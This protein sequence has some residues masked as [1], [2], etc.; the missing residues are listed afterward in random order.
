MPS[1]ENTPPNTGGEGEPIKNDFLPKFLYIFRNTPVHIPVSFF[2]RLDGVVSSFICGGKTPRIAKRKLQLPLSS[3]GLA[4]PCFRKYYWAAV[5]VTV[6]WWF[7]QTRFNPMVNLEAAIMGSYS[8]LTNLVYRGT[9]ASPQALPMRTTVLVW[10]KV[11]AAV[12]TPDTISPHTPLW[13]NPKLS[14]FRSIP[15]PSVWARF[16]IVKMQQI[17]PAGFPSQNCA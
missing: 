3:G 9:K 16:G 12:G 11:T 2:H 14:H 1:L 6:R 7:K 5:L 4:L 17:M 15:D 8:T 13:G 10:E